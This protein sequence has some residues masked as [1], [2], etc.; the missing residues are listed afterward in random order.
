VLLKETTSFY[1]WLVAAFALDGIEHIGEPGVLS[2]P[3]FLMFLSTLAVATIGFATIRLLKS[4]GR[5]QL[6]A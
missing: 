1:A 5:L 6:P 4:S 3:D 2:R